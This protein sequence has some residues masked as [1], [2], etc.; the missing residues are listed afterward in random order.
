M[1]QIFIKYYNHLGKFLE[2]IDEDKHQKCK[3]QNESFSTTTA[4]NSNSGFN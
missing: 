1:D 2:G 4:V 3:D